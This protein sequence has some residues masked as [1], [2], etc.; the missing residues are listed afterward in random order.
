MFVL[1][2]R[3]PELLVPGML[4]A[5]IAAAVLFAFG[6]CLWG[7]R[8]ALSSCATFLWVAFVLLATLAPLRADALY[9]VSE[10]AGQRL[11]AMPTGDL[12]AV[13]ANDQ[14]LLNLLLFVPF[15]LVVTCFRRSAAVAL[16]AA[17]TVLPLGIEMV[18]FLARRLYRLCDGSDVMDNWLGLLVGLA[19]GALIVLVVHGVRRVRRQPSSRTNAS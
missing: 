2:Y 11:C 10:R 1:G 8:T 13:L 18:Q 7:L 5:L 3:A 6:R 17:V 16:G 14:R 9:M 15:G 19:M 4:V 12:A